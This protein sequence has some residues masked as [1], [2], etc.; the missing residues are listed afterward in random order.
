MAVT[1][2]AGGPPHVIEA[3]DTYIFTESFTD[4]PRTNWSSSFLL[5]IPGSAPYRTNATNAT[6]GISFLF[7]LNANVTAN[8][9]PGRY[10]FSE[11]VTELSSG[12]R[13]TAKTGVLQV[14]QDL[15]QAAVPSSA[16]TM[17]A[18]IETAITQLTQGGFSSVSV[19]NVSYTRF[20]VTVLIGMRTRLQAEVFREK[21]ADDA[22]RGI[23]TSGRIGT[24]FKT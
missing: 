17:L 22:F 13:A 3:G 20:D 10:S 4:F 6:D 5:Q 9:S 8:W 1:T 16:A 21:Q 2:T 12:Q 19:N 23:E 11:Y 15:S 18:N 14:I 24:R 7:T